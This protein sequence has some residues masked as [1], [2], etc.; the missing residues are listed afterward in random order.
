MG[1]H[2]E[3]RVCETCFDVVLAWLNQATAAPEDPSVASSDSAGSM[4]DRAASTE[5]V[6]SEDGS[7]ADRGGQSGGGF[8]RRALSKVEKADSKLLQKGIQFGRSVSTEL[9]TRG[10]KVVEAGKIALEGTVA[11]SARIA[12]LRWPHA[13]CTFYGPQECAGQRAAGSATRVGQVLYKPKVFAQQKGSL[14]L[15]KLVG[16]SLSNLNV[17]VEADA[18]PVLFAERLRG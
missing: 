4:L 7:P 18:K 15:S 5:S 14:N 16:V 2:T 17:Q 12:A 13:L 3:Q 1:L 8:F 10:E 6:R 11:L 9:V